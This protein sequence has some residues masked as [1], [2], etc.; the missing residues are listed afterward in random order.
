VHRRTFLVGLGAVPLA[1]A[2]DVPAAGAQPRAAQDF[3]DARTFRSGDLVW[4]KKKGA[5]VPQTRSVLPA[6]NR[7]RRAWEAARQRMLADPAAAGLSPEVAKRLA[8]MSY[9]EFDRLYF[10][11]SAAEQPKSGLH[12]RGLGAMRYPISVGHVG[13]IEVDA[14]GVPYIV[15]ATPNRANGAP[16]GVIRLQYA[17]WLTSYTNIQVWHGRLRD[18]GADASRRV[19]D[20]AL[21]QLGKPYDF[22]NFDLDDDRGFYCSKLVWMCVWRAAGFAADDNP[23]P[24]RGSRFPPW[25]SPKALIGVRHVSLLHSPGDY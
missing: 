23:D 16:G 1:A 17:E 14:A 3:P 2:A 13:L 24:H 19:L 9:E 7:D 4:P 22:F 15:E 5:H 8:D 20:V 18:L 25:F 12:T 11:L 10:S 6:Q 21:A